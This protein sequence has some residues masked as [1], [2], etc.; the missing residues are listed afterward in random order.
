[1]EQ[2]ENARDI[3]GVVFLFYCGMIRGARYC[4]GILRHKRFPF[5]GIILA[6]IINAVFCYTHAVQ[7][8]HDRQII[9]DAD[10][11]LIFSA[12]QRTQDFRGLDGNTFDFMP[13]FFPAVIHDCVN[14]IILSVQAEETFR[15]IARAEE[16]QLAGI[17]VPENIDEQ[18][19]IFFRGIVQTLP[20]GIDHIVTAP[21]CLV[22][23]SQRLFLAKIRKKIP[24][25][26]LP[27]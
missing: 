2:V 9:F 20:V 15:K 25:Q 5:P 6:G 12:L 21:A 1:M 18:L 27:F 16:D 11:D 14:R 24:L 19:L 3:A 17:C 4:I 23:F 10:Q 7:L 13:P 22:I 8:L 26:F